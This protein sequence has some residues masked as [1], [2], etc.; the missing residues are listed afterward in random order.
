MAYTH[1]CYLLHVPWLYNCAS[2]SFTL[3]HRQPA[4][5][6]TPFPMPILI[7]LSFHSRK[8]DIRRSRGPPLQLFLIL[9]PGRSV[10]RGAWIV[11]WLAIKSH[12]AARHKYEKYASTPLLNQLPVNYGALN[13]LKVAPKQRKVTLQLRKPPHKVWFTFGWKIY[14]AVFQMGKYGNIFELEHL[15]CVFIKFKYF[16]VFARVSGCGQGPFSR[17][18]SFSKLY[19]YGWIRFRRGRPSFHI[20]NSKNWFF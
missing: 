14:F 9:P 15:S 10:R 3:R 17:F 7:S 16:S 6:S 13:S 4:A 19:I 5:M 18:L 20:L 11:F 1:I 2:P 8:S 12:W